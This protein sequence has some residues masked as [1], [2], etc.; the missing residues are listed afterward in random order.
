M[1]SAIT[2]GTWAALELKQRNI[3][4]ASPPPKVS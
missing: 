4:G 1:V 3:E 2:K